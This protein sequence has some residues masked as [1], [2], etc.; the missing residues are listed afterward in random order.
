SVFV[1]FTGIEPTQ[2]PPFIPHLRGGS[3]LAGKDKESVLRDS[4]FSP[5]TIAHEYARIVLLFIYRVKGVL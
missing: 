4:F 2:A 1:L 3:L 5:Y